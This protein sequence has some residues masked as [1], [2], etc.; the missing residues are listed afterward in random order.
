MCNNKLFFALLIL[1][2]VALQLPLAALE[3]GESYEIDMRFESWRLSLK[4]DTAIYKLYGK[5]GEPDRIERKIIDKTLDKIKYQVST[6]RGEMLV[7]EKTER[8][9]LKEMERKLF[10]ARLRE[11]G[12]VF[13]E[14]R[15]TFQG[16]IYNCQSLQSPD[17][18]VEIYS[19]KVPAGGLMKKLNPEGDLLRELVAIRYGRNEGSAVT[20][21]K[22]EV[23]QSEHVGKTA[24]NVSEL[25]QGIRK[26][27]GQIRKSSKGRK[28]VV[29]GNIGT[30]Q[31]KKKQYNT[32]LEE[33]KEDGGVPTDEFISD[34][35]LLVAGFNRL[36]AVAGYHLIRS[37]EP[38]SDEGPAAPVKVTINY[39][40][41]LSATN[42]DPPRGVFK[43]THNEKIETADVVLGKNPF[44]D[45]KAFKLHPEAVKI[46]PGTFNCFHIRLVTP[47]LLTSVR[48]GQNLQ[49]STVT[50][51]KVDYW[52]SNVKGFMVV[53]KKIEADRQEITKVMLDGS[54]SAPQTEKI[55]IV[56][57]WTLTGFNPPASLPKTE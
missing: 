50:D 19:Q 4:G 15:F 10:P 26:E 30:M 32:F 31:E 47:K 39:E 20:S 29:I 11:K 17:G 28:K 24:T 49:V 36:N 5:Q 41:F 34:A 52:I 38:S 1:F 42:G 40:K 35:P 54:G 23:I 48:E 9:D 46:I 44:P 18:S 7:E 25:M 14:T 12:I 33:V 37:V 2:Y 22:D 3:E 27:R 6:Y 57:K 51:K 55:T 8:L 16:S 45:M 43:I 13:S 21:I 53:V 56:K